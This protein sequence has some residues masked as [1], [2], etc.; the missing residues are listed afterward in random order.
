MGLP[1]G[2][3]FSYI[4]MCH[5]ENDWLDDCPLAFKPLIYQRYIDDCFVLFREKSHC[6]AFL[7]YLNEKHRNI[8]FTMELES[9][10]KLSFLD[11]TIHK[12]NN[13]FQIS[14]FRKDSF[15]GLGTSY[16]SFCSNLFKVN[17][18]K[19]LLSR[20]YN[21]CSTFEFLHQKFEF[22]K[23]FF[24]CNGYPFLLIDSIICKFLDKIY[25]NVNQ[26]CNVEKMELYVSLPFFDHRPKSLK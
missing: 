9:N 19:T 21:I 14:V 24:S 4:F 15:F 16:F 3:T 12:G 18:V 10:N 6:S 5:H 25:D 13:K 17:S 23:T 2:P 20:A 22:L 11:M 26:T 1:L 8:K 7:N